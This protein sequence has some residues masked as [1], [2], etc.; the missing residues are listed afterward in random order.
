MAEYFMK[1][2]FLLLTPAVALIPRIRFPYMSNLS[3]NI[4]LYR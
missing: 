1:D 3:L 2:V 4:G